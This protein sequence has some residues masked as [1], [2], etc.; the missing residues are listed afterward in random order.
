MKKEFVVSRIEATQDD[1]LYVY[2]AFNDP[3]EYRAGGER[4]QKNP[5]GAN[6]MA[7]TSPEDLMKNLPKAMANISKAIGGGGG[8]SDSP[9]F[10]LTMKEYEDIGIKVGDKVS[11]EIKKAEDAGDFYR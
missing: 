9:T 7:F 10:K 3:T 2:V 8:V 6:V 1:A 11:I 4:L 5:F